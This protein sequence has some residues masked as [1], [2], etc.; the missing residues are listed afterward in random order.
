MVSIPSVS[1]NDLKNRRQQLQSRRR[2]KAWQGI[3]RLLFISSMAGG[4]FWT[5]SLPQWAIE[6][7]SQIEVEGNQL[8]SETQVKDL[9]ALSYPQ[10][11]WELPIQQLSQQ[12]E[13]APPLL[14]VKVVRHVF[15]AK[16]TIQV[17]ER[18]P[19]AIAIANNKVEG[20]LDERGVFIP[21]TFY[22]TDNK[23]LKS[24]SLKA[25]G[26][27]EE[28]RPYW[29]QLYP[30]ILASTVKILAIDW[31][32]PNNLVLKT[33][34]GTVHFGLGTSLPDKF[35]ALARMKKLPSRLPLSKVS[36]IDLSQPDT[37]VIELKPGKPKQT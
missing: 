31:Q 13:T 18:Q 11:V 25:I 26:F 32:D 12:L 5:I 27:E 4:L 16:L 9:L 24:L 19:V 22:Q 20:F 30:L 14:D 10:S 8:L 33:E 34:L 35:T 15:P 1:P 7:K 36:Y 21:K 37:P 2:A 3:W 28:Y 17:K 6:E 23:N 29:Q